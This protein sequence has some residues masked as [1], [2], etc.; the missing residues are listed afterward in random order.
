MNDFFWLHFKCNDYIK[1]IM[2][3]INIKN[4]IETQKS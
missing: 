3:K 2:L 4:V 1:K